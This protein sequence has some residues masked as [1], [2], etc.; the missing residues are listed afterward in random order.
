M[1]STSSR[2]AAV[3]LLNRCL[4]G[5]RWTASL[6]DSVLAESSGR[7]L[8][9]IVV[10]Q[11]ADRFEPILCST[12]ADLFSEVI[13]RYRPEFDARTLRTRYERIRATRNCRQ[14]PRT[15]Y[16]LSR[17]TLGADVAITSIVLDGVKRR[18]DQARIVFVGSQKN[19]ELFAAD[20]RVTHL[21]FE[22]TRTGTLAERLASSPVIRDEQSIVVDP[23]SRLTQLGLLPCCPDE[24][25]YFFESRGYGGD[26]Q[27]PLTTLTREWVG[28]TFN[29]EARPYIAPAHAADTRE[30][31]V[32]LGV[33]DNP[34]K[35]LDD[36][37]E[38][39][40]LERLS[41]TGRSILIDTGASSAEVARVERASAGL[42][43]ITR[44]QGAYAPFAAAIARS[45]LYVG[46]DSAGQHVAAACGVPL[47][48]IFA[49]AVTER[50]SQRWR[51]EGHGR[52]QAIRV[53]DREPAVVLAEVERALRS[54]GL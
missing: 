22:Y 36:T 7:D 2:S 37:F 12:Y 9:T 26:S 33:G 34:E 25:Y 43:N 48:S 40:L 21:P 14:D 6:L 32:S 20:A 41:R 50:F 16:V 8:F 44:W 35:R 10:E 42:Q 18:F 5:E 31:T 11:L 28:R 13:A 4:A 19:Y 49:G 30:V 51:P 38:R 39:S 47:I 46:Y 1:A 52:S 3:E 15:V 23:D 27:L 54:E 17:V 29:V 53:T 45:K 24:D